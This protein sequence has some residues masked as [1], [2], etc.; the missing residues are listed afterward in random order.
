M[1]QFVI[2]LDVLPQRLLVGEG[3]AT[4]AVRA[5]QGDV[6]LPTTGL[7]MGQAGTCAK[8]KTLANGRGMVV[9]LLIQEGGEKRNIKTVHNIGIIETS[10]CLTSPT[11]LFFRLNLWEFGFMSAC[12]IY[13][14]LRI[15]MPAS[16]T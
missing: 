3:L 10:L 15:P 12:N 2:P 4:R 9:P 11:D 6:H 5:G 16:P 1:L 13:E 7:H 14:L 8:A